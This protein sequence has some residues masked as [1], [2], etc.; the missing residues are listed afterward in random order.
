RRIAGLILEVL[1]KKVPADAPATSELLVEF[2]FDELRE[3]IEA[4]LVLRSEIKD[5]DAALERAL[6][7]LHEQ[8]VIILQQGLAIFRSAMTI[9]LQ[10][11]A[12]GERYKTSDYQPLEHHYRERVL[13]VHVMSEFARR[14]IQAIGEALRLVLAYFTLDK[15]EFLQ[16]YFRS[17][18]ELLRYA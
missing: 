2:A 8:Q 10:P 13:Q 17:R 14:G 6:M 9:K 3:A 7:F 18:L 4:D 12:K 1:F 5:M 16:T 15:V 11:H